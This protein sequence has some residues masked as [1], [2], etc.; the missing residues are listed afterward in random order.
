[1]TRN[2]TIVPLSIHYCEVRK[3][4][5]N[6]QMRALCSLASKNKF[7]CTWSLPAHSDSCW[8]RTCRQRISYVPFR[9]SCGNVDTWLSK[10]SV[11]FCCIVL[12]LDFYSLLWVCFRLS[13]IT[14]VYRSAMQIYNVK[15]DPIL[16]AQLLELITCD[17]K[18][19]RFLFR[20]SRLLILWKSSITNTL[21]NHK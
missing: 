6:A 8:I 10:Q 3:R 2:T 15:L 18:V 12:F 20:R 13:Y 1:V 4:F 9:W 16:Q 11:L 21:F 7:S 14:V 17:L 5:P 19:T